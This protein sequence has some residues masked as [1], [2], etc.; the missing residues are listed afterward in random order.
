MKEENRR[1]KEERRSRARY[2]TKNANVP[3][4]FKKCPFYVPFVIINFVSCHDPN[5]KVAERTKRVL[6]EEIRRKK[7]ERKSRARHLT[8]NANTEEL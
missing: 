3:F 2:L 4:I 8:K 7:E 1:K 6:K 5:R